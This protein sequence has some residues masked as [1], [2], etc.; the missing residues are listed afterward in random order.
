MM[1]DTKFPLQRWH[2]VGFTALVVGTI[3]SAIWIVHGI[4]EQGMRMAIR[5][6][7]RSS[8]L[9]FVS[10]FVASSLRKL[11]SMPLSAW[12]LKNR[13]YL[14]VSMAVSHTYHAI[15]LFGLWLATSGAAP[16]PEPLGTFGYFLLIAMTITSFDRSATWL[17]KR[18]WKI[19]HT[20]GMHFFWL[21]LLFEYGFKLPKSPFIYSPFLS[22]L[23]LAMMLR[24]ASSRRQRKLAS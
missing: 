10:A 15:A 9:L 23:I 16:K 21:G 17:G 8:C 24:L 12:L 20:T 3:V 13:R 4:D 18:R 7:G 22:L 2:I 6:T 11:W 14:G 19:L 1:S 5:A